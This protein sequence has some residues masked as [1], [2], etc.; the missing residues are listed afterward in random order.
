MTAADPASWVDPPRRGS[1]MPFSRGLRASR[2]PGRFRDQARV[3]S[4]GPARRSGGRHTSRRSGGFAVVLSG[5]GPA[6]G[7]RVREELHPSRADPLDDIGYTV[8]TAYIGTNEREEPMDT[9]T[10]PLEQRTI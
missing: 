7:M 3:I 8:Y 9:T 6:W 2:R 4:E 1:G 10:H 5:V